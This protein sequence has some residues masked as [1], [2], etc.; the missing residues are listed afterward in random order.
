M[1]KIAILGCENSHANPF[2]ELIRQGEYPDIEVAGIYSNEPEAAKKLHDTYGVPIL[3]HY[4]DMVGKVDGIMITARH[5][6]NHYKYA[7]PY[8]DDGIPM[9]IDKPITCTER[10]AE[11]FMDEAERKGVRLCGGSTCAGYPNTVKLAATVRDKAVGEIRG[12]ALVCPFYFDSPYGG[13]Y[14]YAQHLV[15]IMTTIFGVEAERVF[16]CRGTDELTFV[17]Q[18]DGFSVTGKYLEGG[19]YYSASVYGSESMMCEELTG[20]G[21]SFKNEM[22]DMLSLLRGEGMKKSRKDFVKPVYIMNAILRSLDSGKWETVGSY[23]QK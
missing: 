14:F 22:N 11:E 2:L 17:A 20:Y 4:A 5:G 9:F 3:G 13:F 19:K 6:D 16:A 23:E 15:E 10:D 8:M 1:Y 12:G 21:D 18:Y 7:K